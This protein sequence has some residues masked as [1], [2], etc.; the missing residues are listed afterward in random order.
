MSP[1]PTASGPTALGYTASILDPTRID[2]SN[3]QLRYTPSTRAPAMCR[4][5]ISPSSGSWLKDLLFEVGYVG[6]HGVK[7]MTLAT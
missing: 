5:G 6:N 7:L 1:T 4:A 2:L 3:V